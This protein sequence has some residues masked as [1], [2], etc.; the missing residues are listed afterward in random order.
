MPRFRLD[1]P[2]RPASSS[3]RLHMCTHAL[4]AP[5]LVTPAQTQG[6]AVRLGAARLRSCSGGG[7]WSSSCCWVPRPS[8]CTPHRLRCRCTA[9]APQAHCLRAARCC[10]PAGQWHLRIR[11]SGQ[12]VPPPRRAW[13]SQRA[14]GVPGHGIGAHMS[15][16]CRRINPAAPPPGGAQHVRTCSPAKQSPGGIRPCHALPFRRCPASPTRWPPMA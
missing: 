9:A 5:C 16:L 12:P 14:S 3:L 2:C 7:R 13:A 1:A 8:S 4:A 6:A 10:R 11:P 15:M